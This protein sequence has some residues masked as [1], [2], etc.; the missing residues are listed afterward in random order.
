MTDILLGHDICLCYYYYYRYFHHC[1]FVTFTVVVF[2]RYFHHCCF[3][4]F[5]VVVFGCV[6]SG[7]YDGDDD[8]DDD[9]ICVSFIR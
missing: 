1:C 9:W 7:R 2:Y 6:I 5:T 8:S 3:V 4:T